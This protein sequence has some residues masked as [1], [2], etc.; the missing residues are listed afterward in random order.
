MKNQADSVRQMF[1]T[2][3]PRYDF[4]NRLLS[5]RR[6]VVWRKRVK[7]Y[8]PSKQ[9]KFELLDVATGTGDL[10]LSLVTESSRIT[11]AVGVDVAD[12]M[13]QIGRKK[14]K[15]LGL[16]IPIELQN[17][18][19]CE[20][21][22]EDSSFDIVTIGFG[23]RNVANPMKALSEMLRVLRP[24]GRLIVLEFSIPRNFLVKAVYL[25]YFRHVLPRIAGLFTGQ[26]D[27]YQYLNRTV[28]KFPCGGAFVEMM[29]DAGFKQIRARRLTCGVAQIYFGDRA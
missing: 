8:F 20:L 10:L 28:E 15:A 16:A 6:D 17:A 26:R 22:F 4:I 24:G 23:I 18:D 13:L 19:A 21:P 9:A 27:A 25:A 5:L 1:D 29:R 12:K 2:I 7:N 11:R 14:I 3:A